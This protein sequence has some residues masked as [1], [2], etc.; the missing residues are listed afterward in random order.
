MSCRFPAGAND[1]EKFWSL[2]SKGK[3]A[4]SDVPA[5][6]F[7]WRSFYHPNSDINGVLNHR[8]GHFLEQDVAAFDA[9]FFG[10]PPS[11]ANAMDPQQRLQ[12]E[13][14]YE[15]L[16]NA[17]LLI[18]QVQGSKTGV[19]VA[20]F[21]RDY[22]RMAYKDSEDFARYHM[23]GAGDAIISNRISYTFD[24]KGPSI[25]ID[26]G[27]SGSLVALHS[28]CQSLRTGE[29]NMSLVGG[30]NLILSPDPMVPMSLLHVLNSDGQCFAFDS[31]GSGYGR[32]E[33]VATVVLKRLDDALQ[34][35]DCIRAIIRHTGVNQDGKTTGIF[36]PDQ[37]AQED[38]VR[39]VYSDA[40]IDLRCVQSVEAHG[41]GTLTGDTTEMKSIS[42]VFCK[43]SGRKDRLF[44][45]SVKSNIGHLE[46][47]SGL[48]GLIKTILSLEKGFIPPSINLEQPKAG[49]QDELQYITI[50]RLLE[51]FP[52]SGAASRI[53]SVNSFGYGGT[54]AHVILEDAKARTPKA[55]AEWSGV[56]EVNGVHNVPWDK[57]LIEE[58]IINYHSESLPASA[59]FSNNHC[60]GHGGCRTGKQQI[61]D[62]GDL[63]PHLLIL[64]AKSERSLLQQMKAIAAWLSDRSDRNPSIADLAYTLCSRRSHMFWRC[65]F[66]AESFQELRSALTQQSPNLIKAA[67]TIHLNFIFTGQGAQWYAMGRDLIHTAPTF[68][69]SLVS[70]ENVLRTLGSTWSLFTELLRDEATSKLD[71]SVIAQPAT[72]AIQIALVD[73]LFSLG[74]KPVAVLGHSSGEIAAAYAAGAL[75][76]TVALSVSYH[77]GFIAKE[78]KHDDNNGGAMLAVGLGIEEVQGYVTQLHTGSVTV[79]CIN[80]LKST[81]IS[82]DRSAIDELK[83]ILDAKAVFSRELK[84]EVAYHSHHMQ[85]VAL[86]YLEALKCLD[87]GLH[88]PSTKF[89]SSVTA[90][91]KTSGFGPT[92]WVQNLTSQVRFSEAFTQLYHN[93]IADGMSPTDTAMAYVEVGPH[94]SL[95]GP[96]HQILS[97]ISPESVKKVYIPSLVRHRSGL[98]T[99]L[100]LT[101]RLFDLGHPILFDR[102]ILGER[103]CHNLKVIHDLPPYQWDH[104]SVYWHES[105]LSREHRLRKNPPH[106]LLG[107]RSPSG[108]S[109]EPAW[110]NFLSLD[111]L[112]W[113]QDHV[114]DDSIIFPGSGYVCMAV[115]AMRQEIENRQSRGRV[116]QY[117][118]RDIVFSKAILIPALPGKIE[119]QLSL[120]PSRNLNNRNTTGWTDF[121]ICSLSHDDVWNENCWGSIMVEFWPSADEVEQ[122]G[123]ADTSAMFQSGMSSSAIETYSSDQL[124][125]TLRAQGNDYG[126]SF[127]IMDDLRIGNYEAVGTVVIPDVG[128]CMPS[129]FMQPHL[130]HPSTLDALFHA[131]LPLFSRYCSPGS[132]MPLSIEEV[133]IPADSINVPGHKFEVTTTLT[134]IGTRSASTSILAYPTPSTGAKNS[135]LII[136]CAELYSVGEV[137]KVDRSS[138]KDR[139]I[140]Y[141][142]RLGLDSDFITQDMVKVSGSLD[143]DQDEASAAVL[144]ADLLDCAASLYIKKLIDS[145][146]GQHRVNHAEHFV[147]LLTWMRQFSESASFEKFVNMSPDEAAHT[148]LE[149]QHSGIEGETLHRLGQNLEL[150]LSGEVDSLDLLLEGS[151]LFRLYADESCLRCYSYLAAFVKYL[152]FKNPKMHILEIGAGTGGA[153]VP[154]LQTLTEQGHM[155]FGQY[156]FTD[157]SPS[158]FEP[159][160]TLLGDWLERITFKTFNVERDPVTQGFEAA[161]YDLVIASN[162]LHAT[163]KIDETLAN[164]QKVLKPGGRLAL[165]ELTNLRPSKNVIFGLLPGWWRGVEDG[166]EDSPVLSVERWN[167]ILARQGFSGAEIVVKD[168]EGPANQ[169][170]MMAARSLPQSR[171]SL[172]PVNVICEPT[173]TAEKTIFSQGIVQ[174]LQRKGFDIQCTPWI[175]EPTGDGTVHM[176]IDSSDGFLLARPSS[177]QFMQIRNLVTR[178]KKIFWVT[179]QG[180]HSTIV[181]SRRALITGFARSARSENEGLQLVTLDLTLSPRSAENLELNVISEAFSACFDPNRRS[182]VPESEYT[183]RNGQLLVPRLVPDLKLNSIVTGAANDC[184]EELTMFQQSQ[185]SLRLHVQKPGLL[186]SLIFVDDGSMLIEISDDELEIETKAFGINFKDIFIALGQMKGSTPMGGECAGVVVAAGSK[187]RSR[188][189]VGDRVCAWYATPYANRARVK[190]CCACRIPESISFSSAASIPVVFL[191][192]YYGLVEIARLRQHQTVLIHS[193]AGGVGQAAVMIAKSL[194]AYILATVGNSAKRQML[195]EKYGIPEDHIFSS[196]SRGF[197]KK[198]LQYTGGEG[199]DVVLNS[200]AGEALVDS[201]DCIAKFGTF[202]EI[203]KSDIQRNSQLSMK[204]FERNVC[205]AS[206]DLV[207]LANHRP[208]I[209]RS[210]L[211]R[212]LLMF[213]KGQLAVVQPIVTLPISKIENAFR[214]I[215]SGKHVGKVILTIEEKSM[216]K[217]MSPRTGPLYL[218]SSHTFVVAGGF[219]GLG[220]RILRFMA[221][222]GAKHILVLSRRNLNDV[223]RQAL[224]ADLGSL[225]ARVYIERCDISSLTE[226]YGVAARCRETLPP[227]KGIIQAA[228]VLQDRI[229]EQMSMEDYMNVVQ[230][231]VDGTLNLSEAFKGPSLEF[232]IMLSSVASVSGPRSQANYAAA[233]AFQDQF[234]RSQ[235]DSPTQYV[236]LNLGMIDESDIIAQNPDLRRS[237]IR[238]GCIPLKLG[239]LFALLAYAMSGQIRHDGLN[240]VVMGFDRQSISESSRSDLLGTALF[241][242]LSYTEEGTD[243]WPTAQTSQTVDKSIARAASLEEIHEIMAAAIVQ[244]ISSLLAINIENINLDSPMESLGLDSLIAIEL[245]TWIARTFKAAMQTS[246]ILDTLNLRALVVTAAQRSTLAHANC[247][248]NSA[249]GTALERREVNDMS[250]IP[251]IETAPVSL[252]LLPLQDLE[253]TLEFFLYSMRPL[254]SAQEFQDLS[255][256]IQ[257]FQ[258]PGGLGQILQGRLQG[259]VDDVHI[260]DWL[261]D[262]YTAHVYL[263]QRKPIN[264]WGA[265]FGCHV[266][267]PFVHTQSERASI[268]ATAAFEFK[269]RLESGQVEQQMLNGEPL[270]MDSLKWI[271]H[272]YREPRTCVDKVYTA[273]KNAYFVAMRRGHFFKVPLSR[274]GANV[275]TS[276]MVRIFEGILQRDVS[277]GP[278]VAALTADNRD[279]WAEVRNLVKKADHANQSL[280]HM[281]EA[282]AFLICLDETSP[283]TSTERAN[284]FMWGDIGNRWSDKPLQFAV[285]PNGVSAYIVEHSLIDASTLAKLAKPIKLAIERYQRQGHVG[286]KVNSTVHDDLEE[287]SF[288]SNAEIDNHI[289]RVQQEFITR[290]ITTEYIHTTC[291]DF[292][293]TFLRRHNCGANTGIQIVIQLASLRYFGHL[294]PCWETIGMR[295]FHKGR[296]DLVQAVLPPVADFCNAMNDPTILQPIRRDLFYKAAK[297]YTSAVNRISRG[298]GFTQH[299]YALQEVAEEKEK[300]LW[301]GEDSVYRRTR[302]AK[303]MTDCTNWENA[304]TEGGY[305]MPDP[306]HLW[307]H[308][309]V[310]D[311]SDDWKVARGIA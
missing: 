104:S 37:Q 157:I 113:L 233:N 283:D 172:P 256:M 99:V 173:A 310:L 183:Y 193:A 130:M 294:P 180:R 237:V 92:Y 169:M 48:A 250:A 217:A 289:I 140:T 40:S 25:T 175:A 1:P 149:A 189:Q 284:Q 39:Q 127:A 231:K 112:P 93:Q 216:V 261:Y 71:D 122:F 185:R 280:T 26:T 271:F 116:L 292:G 254:C 279:S 194:G 287:Y 66:V 202:V 301:L 300:I 80:S 131:G 305:P 199:V 28:A 241:S 268:I 162:V 206:L 45:G 77:R 166:R 225:G 262:L 97:Q 86:R 101:G 181:D 72:T 205:F 212:L 156:D 117:M 153:T 224:D 276:A 10:I 16:E 171:S 17:G 201:W 260:D 73:L 14:A 263:K 126:P 158:F 118:L 51:P 240:Q 119:I 167:D 76:H 46:S 9:N 62:P 207:G 146:T 259:R 44:V 69:K 135:P 88:L 155:T 59:R 100:A 137:Q 221:E 163:R 290:I 274:N 255:F 197:K 257:N 187:A 243:L 95:A 297:A 147:H 238:S 128:M 61:S 273:S 229:L 23:T 296:V 161:S 222:R 178:A 230:P 89:F 304:I 65:S 81:T 4:W 278:R 144:N 232:F 170:C 295:A 107:V 22:D 57:D 270:C 247:M 190:E 108:T 299:I 70:S 203:G 142:L 160:K 5:T 196:R 90:C 52:A 236:S 8:G 198:V 50:P 223:D 121:R 298:R 211:E 38:L 24:F 293:S 267:S 15:A 177:K 306:E 214:L 106:D 105:R 291:V 82:G 281:I 288:V 125:Q 103:D 208:Q 27:C 215:Q 210:L 13:S 286:G 136:S 307:I 49:L 164:I 85:K 141:Q 179:L 191:T 18:N 12:L 3:S 143:L 67:G 109:M 87:F 165:I 245:K 30:T 186:D 20:I 252:P 64:T 182:V 21:S 58:P 47:A 209:L 235:V 302:P 123:E 56:E 272:S 176:V 96:T 111:R 19:Y 54:N 239:E 246:E 41:T 120:R 154:L 265:F 145:N 168:F 115:E 251:G 308:Y 282:A 253:S 303:I 234:A 75:S 244:Q 188:I 35:H 159:A 220:R 309:E 132:V 98:Q 42:K 124:Y 249:D 83:E 6:R 68:R 277:Y 134:P 266:D 138:V 34:A 242:Q 55:S 32:G 228:M 33:G 227:I 114:V 275:S 60:N 219:G 91:E 264:P 213:E 311:A 78:C 79:A 192:A 53:A 2:L 63:R 148:L 139:S 84:V 110:R 102:F 258:S 174:T 74:I 94:S 248:N 129:G 11:E 204:P 269:Q 36:V 43:E 29:T 218:D 184:L 195:K 7:R 200:L 226:V 133:I 285:C 151:L 152:V 150:I 31:R